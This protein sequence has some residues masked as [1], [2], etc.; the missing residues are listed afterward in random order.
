MPVTRR[1]EIIN[2]AKAKGTLII[3]DDYNGELRYS[4]HPMP[5]VQNYDTENTVYIGSFSKV[6]LPSVRISYMVLPDRLMKQYREIKSLTNQT[7]SKTEQLALAG[8]INTGKI[9]VHLRKARR[10]YLEKSKTVIKSVEKHFKG[11]EFVFNETSLYVKI[12]LN[13]DIDREKAEKDF[14]DNS[15]C[16]MPTKKGELGL[17]FSGSPNDKIDEGIRLISE[18]INKNKR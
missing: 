14:A 12:K 18:I 17:S 13:F 8:Y 7:A 5:C 3:E 4:T 15:I 11:C 2:G 16:V 6:L 1:L 10:V 9:D